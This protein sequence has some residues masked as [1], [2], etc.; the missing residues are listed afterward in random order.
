MNTMDEPKV[1]EQEW[2]TFL[3]IADRLKIP[4]RELLQK[5]V[6]FSVLEAAAHQFGRALARETTER[7]AGARAERAEVAYDCPA[8]GRRCPV[9]HK[10]RGL[11]TVDGRA[12]LREPVCHC[13]ACDRDFF[14]SASRD[15]TV[16]TGI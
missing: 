13:P 12:R 10:E 2:E 4:V 11:E 5:D 7:L 9:T 14:P 1:T 15:G 6:R 3:G 16:A 8:C